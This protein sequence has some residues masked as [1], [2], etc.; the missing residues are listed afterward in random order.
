MAL[1][2]P[3]DSP[4]LPSDS[5]QVC[6][7]VFYDDP[8]AALEWLQKAFGFR[9]RVAVTDGAGGVVHAETEIGSGVI[10][11]GPSRPGAMASP[12]SIGGVATQN[13]CVYVEN[14]DALYDRARAAGA[15]IDMPIADKHYG[16][17]GF[18]VRDL[19]GHTWWF[20]QRMDQAQWDAAN[21]PFRP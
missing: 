14:V 18:G 4:M 8:H 19:E 9:T 17:R 6:P 2:Q 5:P 10:M 15:Q 7:C 13:V 1:K 12:R 11:I 21:A 3:E 20:A 16:D